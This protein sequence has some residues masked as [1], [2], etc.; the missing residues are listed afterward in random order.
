M[1]QPKL[2]GTRTI[3][4]G[5]DTILISIYIFSSTS[6]TP[7][8]H[9]QMRSPSIQPLQRNF[10]TQLSAL[11]NLPFGNLPF[12]KKLWHHSL[13]PA[14]ASNSA[15]R[16][17]IDGDLDTSVQHAC[18]TVRTEWSQANALWTAAGPNGPSTSRAGPS[19]ILKQ[20]M[21]AIARFFSYSTTCRSWKWAAHVERLDRAFSD[22]SF[23]VDPTFVGRVITCLRDCK[24]S[25]E[26]TICQL[27]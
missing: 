16:E 14:G 20:P 10:A 22:H 27:T 24:L 17:I 7:L 6:R 11:N 1:L 23:N 25:V 9:C 18:S 15:L 12:A 26:R 8:R 5:C 3:T 13:V 2:I 4:W 19:T 21:G